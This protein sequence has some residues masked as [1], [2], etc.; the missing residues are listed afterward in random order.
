MSGKQSVSLKVCSLIYWKLSHLLAIIGLTGRQLSVKS[1]INTVPFVRSPRQGVRHLATA[2]NSTRHSTYCKADSFL[3]RNLLHRYSQTT[4]FNKTM[5]LQVSK[6]AQMELSS[7]AKYHHCLFYS[8]PLCL[9][10]LV[11]TICACYV[12]DHYICHALVAVFC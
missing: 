10:T 7:S 1:N 2:M 5:Q 6:P 4:L 11:T 3:Q 8:T 9:V 12:L